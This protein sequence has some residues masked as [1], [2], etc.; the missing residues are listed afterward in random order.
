MVDAGTTVARN[1]PIFSRFIT[2][3]LSGESVGSSE[4]T[5]CSD[6]RVM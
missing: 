4:K 6:S 5:C 2:P 3:I 1:S